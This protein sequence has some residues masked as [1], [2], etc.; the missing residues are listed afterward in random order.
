MK[1]ASI[2]RVVRFPAE[3]LYQS[4]GPALELIMQTFTQRSVPTAHAMK[5]YRR[6]NKT[7]RITPRFSFH[8][9]DSASSVLSRH[10]NDHPPGRLETVEP[11]GSRVCDSCVN[12]HR[13]G[14]PGYV[15][16][17]V[18]VNNLAVF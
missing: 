16:S 9:Q 4:P 18:A 1:P 2:A 17:T 10:R 5:D 11:R 6:E 15:L 7:S 13:I 3:R 12:K 8:S 14:R